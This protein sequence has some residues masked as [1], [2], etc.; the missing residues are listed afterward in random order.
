MDFRPCI[1]ISITLYRMTLTIPYLLKGFFVILVSSILDLFEDL[2][3]LHQTPGHMKTPLPFSTLQR[4]KNFSPA[5]Q[6]SEPFGILRIFE[7]LP[8]IGMDPLKPFQVLSVTQ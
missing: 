4:Q 2:P 8:G 3:A 6:V 5:I 7:F 1:T